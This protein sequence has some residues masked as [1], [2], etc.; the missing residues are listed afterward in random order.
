[1]LKT[2]AIYFICL[3]FSGSSFA[4][5]AENLHKKNYWSFGFGLILAIC[6]AAMAIKLV[7]GF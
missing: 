2:I 5:A 3:V 6:M 7:L 4:L 1:M